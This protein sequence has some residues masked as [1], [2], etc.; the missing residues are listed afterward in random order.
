M[1]ARRTSGS[2]ARSLPRA[3]ARRAHVPVSMREPLLGK[4]TSR[5]VTAMDETKRMTPE[6]VVAYLLGQEGLG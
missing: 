1:A 3:S 2:E 5:D 6:Q 4:T